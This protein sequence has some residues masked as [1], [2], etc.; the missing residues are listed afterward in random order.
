LKKLSKEKGVIEAKVNY[1]SEQADIKYDPSL[2]DIDN[3]KSKIE[4]LGY[5]AIIEKSLDLEKQSEEKEKEKKKEEHQMTV[6][7]VT[8]SVLT[9]FV[10]LGSF[11]NWFTFVP[12]FM[13]NSLLLLILA[14][15]IQF[16]VGRS[17]Y[18]ITWSNIRNKSV[19]M[20]TLIVMGTSVAYFYSL[21]AFIFPEL[22]K[23]IG[24]ENVMYFDTSAVVITL[25]LAGKFLE[26]K[27]KRGTNEGLKINRFEVK[28][29]RVIKNG[30]ENDKFG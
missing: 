15:V 8:S 29:A 20:E 6:K 5:K 26:L 25:V 22:L 30:K 28:E 2:F 27:A 9:L 18:Q 14:T 12:D 24:V 4:D 10:V 1:G 3:I 23:R 21:V 7:L 16:W 13:T 11:P 19:S 17:F